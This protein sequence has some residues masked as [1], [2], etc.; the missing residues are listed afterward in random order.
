MSTV[1]SQ[2]ITVTPELVWLD[3][4]ALVSNPAN[5]RGD[6]R[7]LDELV[8][9]IAESG[10]VEPLVVVPLEVGH[11][12]LAGHRRAAAAVMAELDVVPCWV[13]ADLAEAE[14]DQVALALI[15]NV[16]RDDLTPLEE[17]HAYAQLSAFPNWSPGRIAQATGRDEL[18]VRRGI[19]AT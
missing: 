5:V 2:E 12:I 1:S 7:N 10:I 19:E 9:S 4:K 15:E 6:L 11:R 14:S 8:E 18:F 13:R 17:A 3:P 16:Q